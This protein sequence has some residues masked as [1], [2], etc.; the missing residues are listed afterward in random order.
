MMPP[1]SNSPDSNPPG[2][3]SETETPDPII[4]L[5]DD[6]EV[7]Q[8]LTRR[9]FAQSGFR[10]RLECV[11]DG[12][13]CL[14]FLRREP[15]YESAPTPHLVLLDINMPR[16]DGKAVLRAIKTDEKLRRI[17]VVALTTSHSDRDMQEMYDLRANSYIIKPVDFNAFVDIVKSL[18]QYW[19]RTVTLPP[20]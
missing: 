8:F 18:C 9:A 15:P 7:D 10:M 16:M 17:P 13:E 3:T 14:K 1:A 2:S 12:D 20:P 4:L 19:F 11:E 5:V 6:N